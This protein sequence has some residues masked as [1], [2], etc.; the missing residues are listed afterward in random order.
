MRHV[1]GQG[2]EFTTRLASEV[3]PGQSSHCFLAQAGDDAFHFLEC[4][5]FDQDGL[6]GSHVG[7]GE[8]FA[9]DAVEYR[10][11]RGIGPLDGDGQERSGLPL[12]EIVTHRL[13]RHGRI[14]ENTHHVVAH[15]K[16]VPEWQTVRTQSIEHHIGSLR[17]SDH[18]A[19]MKR[20]FDRVLA[21]LVSTDAFGLVASTILS[22]GAHE[23][24]ELTDVEFEPQLVPDRPRSIGDPVEK[25]ITDHE[26]QITDEDRH[27]FAVTTSFAAAATFSMFG[28]E[29]FVGD[30]LTTST[31]GSV[32]D[33][34]V[35]EGEGVQKFES[36]TG[37]DRSRVARIST[38]ADETPVTESG[39]KP[40]AAGSDQTAYLGHRCCQ[41]GIEVGPASLFTIEDFADT[42]LDTARQSDQRR[43]RASGHGFR[44]RVVQSSRPAT[45][46]SICNLA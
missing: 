43:R 11:L 6:G 8:L 45:T 31:P 22:G 12:A 9:P 24:E 44:L 41:V 37:V 40:L 17:S 21:A 38:E 36:G 26:S 34:V 27:S 39:S 3:D 28:R 30:R 18:R 13:S 15:L 10:A 19:Q 42:P 32:H 14:S 7:I 25:S 33:V 2:L 46:F 1:R 35:E 23:V 29:H 20:A 16:R 4:S 5:A